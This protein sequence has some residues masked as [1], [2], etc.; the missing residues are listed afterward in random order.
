M[1]SR[2][3]H[4]GLEAR[5]QRLLADIPSALVLVDPA[6]TILLANAAAER[7]FGYAP[8]E[9]TGQPIECLVPA[10]LRPQHPSHRRAFHAHPQVRMLGGGQTLWG[11]RKDGRE[12][13]LE[14]GLSPIQTETGTLVLAVLVDLTPRQRA[15]ENL[16]Q[17]E[18]A[19]ALIADHVPALLA[20][21]DA[22]GYYRFVNQRYEEWFGVAREAIL[23][24]HCRELASEAAYTKMQPR[25]EAVLAGQH[26]VYQ[27]ILPD[28]RCGRRWIEATYVPDIDDKGRVKGF[29]SF[30]TDITARMLGEEALRERE[31]CYRALFNHMSSGVAVYEAVNDGADFVFRD[32][33]HAAERIERIQ[34]ADLLGK[35]VL[36]IFPG[37]K[38]FGLFEVLQ[39]VWQTGQSEHSPASWYEDNRIAGWR[40]NDVYKLPLGQI[41]A[42]YDDVT[43]RKRTEEALF[44]EKERLQ[45]TLHAI[46]DEVIT[47]DTSGHVEYMNPVA[48]TLTGWSVDEAR[49]RPLQTVWH[50]VHEKSRR[51]V[52]DPVKQCLR[53]G[54]IVRLVGHGLLISRNGDEYSVQ[55]SAAPI[56]DPTGTLLGAVLV[57][58]DVT[59]AR[60]LTHRMAH[61]A[62]HD[63]L[64]GLV[65]RR[66]FEQR[67]KRVL[68]TAREDKTENA[69]CYLDL[70]QFKLIND[71]CGHLAGDAL[72]SQLG[73]LLR[74]QVRERDTL[75]RLGGDE[76]GVLLERCTLEQAC[77]VAH[78]FRE[79]IEDFRFVWEGKVFTIGASIGL[80][81]ITE[82]SENLTHIL[83]A[84]DAACYMAKDEGRNRIHVFREDDAALARRH[85][86]IQWTIHIP[87]ALAEDRFRLCFQPIVS[88]S[89]LDHPPQHH[90]LLL[91]LEN[92]QGQLVPPG[93]FLPAAERYHLIAKID[94]WVIRKALGWLNRHPTYLDRLHLCAIN[95]SGLSLGNEDFLTLTLRQ[96]K[97]TGVPPEKICFEITETAVIANLGVACRFIDV[98]HAQ[99]CCFALDDFGSGLSS[100]AYLKNL[101]VDFVK[102]DGAFVKDVVED[103]LDWVMVKY[104]NEIGHVMGKQTIAEFVEN[105]RILDKLR[106]IGV[107]YA[108][109]YYLGEP[110][111]LEDLGDNEPIS[112]NQTQF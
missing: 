77:R 25:I 79:A 78:A 106:A 108:Q 27:D 84:A 39:R 46:G 101:P 85:R 98:L 15:Q 87:Q 35:G 28:P 105:E 22:N 57:F 41:V 29:Y 12:V 14:I 3:D 73:A 20:Y 94:A 61:Q 11:L 104:I 62:T 56:R 100:F 40:E 49:G 71:H 47:T 65:N 45:V 24:R 44:R 48:E 16:R 31:S 97:E 70:D 51:R 42:V 58:R 67:L 9:L 43:E 91:R 54:H 6:G 88:M 32:F 8:T 55:D 17:R 76:F 21:V 102:I 4:Y 74:T 83:R 95:L 75:A 5:L 80:V 30:M 1:Q 59:E 86:E 69:L 72:L 68:K 2:L 64:T 82:S 96:F 66:E 10:H 13:P 38:T 50:I 110:R 63:A 33:N 60:R 99:G 103:P 107:D 92:P 7:L 26:V 81:P 52:S 23:G 112:L 93:A 111:V 36:E 109:G 34:K 37:V 53:S 90:E 18:R 19:L 89:A